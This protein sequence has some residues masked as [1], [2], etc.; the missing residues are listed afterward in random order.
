[1]KTEVIKIKGMHCASCAG[2]IASNLKKAG[3]VDADVNYPTES[4]R[5]EYD[6]SKINLDKIKQIVKELLQ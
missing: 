2:N 1:M 4:A 6:E 3:V 5:L